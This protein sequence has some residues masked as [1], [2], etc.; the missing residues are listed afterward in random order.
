[1]A[2]EI[3]RS[4]FLRLGGMAAASVVFAMV[5]PRQACAAVQRAKAADQFVNSIG[6]MT[7]QSYFNSAYGNFQAVSDKLV[8]LGVR[9]ARDSAVLSTDA[10]YNRKVYD[11]FKGLAN[12][13]VRYTLIVDPRS[14]G[15]ADID[16][17]KINAIVAHSG[18][19]LEA[20]E[21][22]N[23][24]DLSGRADWAD[25][26][27]AY[28]RSLYQSVKA[29]SSPVPVLAPSLAYATNYDQL[30]DMS[31]YCDFG[32]THPYPGGRN[33]GTS[34]W[35]SG[36]YG[37]LSWNIA[38][39][40]KV[41]G[42]KPIIATETG[43]HNVPGPLGAYSNTGVPEDV[44]GKYIPRLFLHYYDMGLPRVYA[45]EMVDLM[46]DPSKSDWQKHWG[47]L[48]SDYSAKP[49]YVALKRLIG[50]L[51]D[52]GPSFVPGSL[53]YSL[54]GDLTN[55]RQMLFQKRDGRFYL[56]LWQEVLGY[57]V[58]TD[59]YISV[60]PRPVTLRLSTP[61]FKA[62][63]YEPNRQKTPLRSYSMPTEL[64]LQVSD[65]IAVVRLTPK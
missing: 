28:Q 22:P 59:T 41:C 57:N 4:E 53:D 3:S 60:A 36:G 54:S 21:G 30:G 17:A 34:G 12:R 1:L 10:D 45:Y 19:A 40:R 8:A 24:F 6:V 26:L 27:R 32:N 52:P 51:S 48:R 11:R 37:S 64:L 63:V 39:A 23:E 7:H 47:L 31:A 65:R 5:G 43:Y 25:R 62:A 35:G 49:A 56:V 55:V 15:L 29:S 44:S 2:V 18:G 20:V 50:L 14:L 46:G 13:G 9:H 16:S 38:N 61:I 58:D 33:P 42:T